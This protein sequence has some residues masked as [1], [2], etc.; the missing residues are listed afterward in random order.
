V[1][2]AVVYHLRARTHTHKILRSHFAWE[3]SLSARGISTPHI[4]SS[5]TLQAKSGLDRLVSKFLRHW[6]YTHTHTHTHTHTTGRTRRRGR[7]LNNKHKQKRRTS[8]PSAGFEPAIQVIKRLQ[9]YALDRMACRI[10]PVEY[11]TREKRPPPLHQKSCRL[12]T[13]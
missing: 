13:D 10:D 5:V 8:M 12:C 4:I 9:T 1:G 3:E 11:Q 2:P 7:C 6:A